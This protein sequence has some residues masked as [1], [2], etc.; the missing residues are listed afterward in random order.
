M[1][2]FE[3]NWSAPEFEYREKDVAWYWISI[4]IASILIAF[5]AWER[6]FLFGMFIV[7]A[8]MLLVVWG[9]RSPRIID[10]TLTE[11]GLLIGERKLHPINTFESFSADELDEAWHEIIFSFKAKLKTPIRIIVGE[12]KLEEIKKNLKPLVKEVDH[13]PSFLDSLEKIIRF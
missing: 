5:A 4:I 6:N 12:D 1:A 8:E 3:I 10:F 2:S 7:I 9:N 11:K 13:E